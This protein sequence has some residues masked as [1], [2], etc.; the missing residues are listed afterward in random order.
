[1]SRAVGIDAPC[2][3]TAPH[4]HHKAS[5]EDAGAA[6]HPS[7]HWREISGSREAR[8]DGA[9]PDPASTIRIIDIMELKYVVW[10]CA[11]RQTSS[12]IPSNAGVTFSGSIAASAS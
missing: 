3:A 2:A 4:C 8:A 1:M 9:G 12:A 10:R 7:G 11:R 5:S 6:F